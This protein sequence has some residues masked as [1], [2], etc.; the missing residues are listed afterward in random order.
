MIL[1]KI[2]IKYTILFISFC[3]FFNIFKKVFKKMNFSNIKNKLSL[4]NK[5]LYLFLKHIILVILCLFV[6]MYIIFN[7]YMNFDDNIKFAILGFIHGIIT[8]LIFE[9]FDKSFEE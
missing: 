1:V 2:L 6:S 9:L 7:Q 3:I 5:D 4:L 8:S